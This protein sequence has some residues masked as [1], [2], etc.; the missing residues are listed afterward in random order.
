MRSVSVAGRRIC[1]EGRVPHRVITNFLGLIF[2]SFFKL[3]NFFQSKGGLF[4]NNSGGSNSLFGA[5]GSSGGSLFGGNSGGSAS[6]FSGSDG[7]RPSDA[8]LAKMIGT[9]TFAFR[10]VEDGNN[11]LQ[12]GSIS[13]MPEYICKSHE[14]LMVEDMTGQFSSPKAKELLF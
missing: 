9:K 5:Q 8:D 1:S 3:K 6:L 11:R 13:A 10:F 14:E 7:R 2:F 4:G 12:Y